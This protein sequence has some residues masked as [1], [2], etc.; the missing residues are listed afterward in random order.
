MNKLVYLTRDTNKRKGETNTEGWTELLSKTLNSNTINSLAVIVKSLNK[1]QATC[2]QAFLYNQKLTKFLIT[3]QILP[4]TFGNF[5]IDSFVI[6]MLLQKVTQ[7][8]SL[9]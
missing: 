3:S 8:K 1:G 5:L 6:A 9:P 2:R 4:D 7:V